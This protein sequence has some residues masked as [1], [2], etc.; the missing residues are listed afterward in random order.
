MTKNPILIDEGEFI[1]N[2]MEIMKEKKI[3]NIFVINKEVSQRKITGIVHIH[4]CLRNV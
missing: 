4:D 1:K 2:A 3:T